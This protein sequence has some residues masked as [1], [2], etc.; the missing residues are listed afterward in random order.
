MNRR[1]LN[2][3]YGNSFSKLPYLMNSTMKEE[4]LKPVKEW[5]YGSSKISI[6]NLSVTF[7]NQKAFHGYR[8]NRI[9]LYKSFQL[10]LFLI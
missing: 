1:G 8:K 7:K 5:I 6:N 4:N 10:L 3:R 2:T 9:D